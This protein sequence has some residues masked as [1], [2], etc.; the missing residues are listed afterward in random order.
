MVRAVGH[1]PCPPAPFEPDVR[2]PLGYFDPISQELARK[3]FGSLVT[4]LFTSTYNG[5]GGNRTPVPRRL[6]KRLYVHS[7]SFESRGGERR[8]TGFRVPQPDCCFAPTRPGVM[9]G[10]AH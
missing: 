10:L 5:G 9:P 3:C 2:H 7:R 4:P 1:I 6:R 8:P